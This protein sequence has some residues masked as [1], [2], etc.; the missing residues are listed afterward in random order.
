MKKGTGAPGGP[1]NSPGPLIP[2]WPSLAAGPTPHGLPT[3]TSGWLPPPHLLP[4]V[5]LFSPKAKPSH[6]PVE[7]EQVRPVAAVGRLGFL[8]PELLCHP[9]KAGRVNHGEAR[10]R[11][12]V[13]CPSCCP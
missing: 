7:Q 6:R 12:A 13:S 10:E 11:P 4:G 5:R 3:P 9:E 1:R 2:P 8:W